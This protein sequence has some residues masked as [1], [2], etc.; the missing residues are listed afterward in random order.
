MADGQPY[1]V[2]M[3]TVTRIELTDEQLLGALEAVTVGTARRLDKH[4]RGAL[5]SNHE[6]QGIL[7]EE[8]DEFKRAVTANDNQNVAEELIDIAVACVIAVASMVAGATTVEDSCVGCNCNTSD[9]CTKQ[10][11][12]PQHVD[13]DAAAERARQRLIEIVKQSEQK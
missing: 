3:P 11:E 5:A 13:V 10:E 4:G 6:A 9:Q 8:W 12:K 1:G 2:F 7:K